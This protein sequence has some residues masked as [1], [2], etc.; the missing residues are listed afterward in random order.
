MLVMVH[1]PHRD[2]KSGT[3]RSME[4]AL[5]MGMAPS[6][7]VID[8]NNEETVRDVLDRGFWAGVH[9]LSADQ[10]GQRAHGGD[11]SPVRFGTHLHR[12]Q[13]RLGR[14][15]SARRAEDR[16]ADAR[17]R[18]RDEG[19]G[20]HLLRQCA[21]RLWAERPDRPSPTGSNPSRSTSVCCSRAIPF[22]AA[23]YRASMV[24]RQ[25]RSLQ[26]TRLTSSDLSHHSRKPVAV[27]AEI[28]PLRPRWRR[29][30]RRLPAVVLGSV[31][32]PRVLHRATVRS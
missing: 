7:V 25:A 6:K 12:F 22:C 28:T 23:S 29:S 31:R 21:H 18:H 30:L 26:P 15:G 2:K 10:D 17:A 8:H 32:L 5:E 14:V 24:L 13:R 20:G 9:A 11:R 3:V 4:V 1:T 16:Q 19:R 27:S